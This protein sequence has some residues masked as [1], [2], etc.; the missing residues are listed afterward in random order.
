M[1]DITTPVIDRI[2]GMVASIPGWTPIDELF[3]L[4]NLVYA[5]A[6]TRGDVIE[7]GSWCG[8]SSVVLGH[9]ATLT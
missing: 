7:L 5:T 9:A 3:A 4:F 8:R 1:F 2:E 6:H